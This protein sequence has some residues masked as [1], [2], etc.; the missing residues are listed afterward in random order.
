MRRA[1]VKA[2]IQN[3]VHT[4]MHTQTYITLRSLLVLY[5]RA[6]EFFKR[7]N[8]QEMAVGWG[9]VTREHRAAI[10]SYS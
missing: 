2:K 3:C 9:V 6:P 1:R 7:L 10:I 5:D 8:V 4:D